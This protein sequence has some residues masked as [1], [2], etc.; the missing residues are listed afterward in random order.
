MHYHFERSSE[1]NEN[2]DAS[3]ADDDDDGITPSELEERKAQV[4]KSASDAAAAAAAASTAQQRASQ[5]MKQAEMLEARLQAQ[6]RVIQ[7][8]ERERESRDEDEHLHAIL[9]AAQAKS[10]EPVIGG[11][12]L[13]ILIPTLIGVCLLCTCVC[14]GYAILR[15][16]LL[17]V[18]STSHQGG[19][20]P[21]PPEYPWPVRFPAF[22]GGASFIHRPQALPTAEPAEFGPVAHTVAMGGAGRPAEWNGHAHFAAGSRMHGDGRVAL[23]G[24]SAV[25]SAADSA[26]FH[27]TCL[28]ASQYQQPT[29]EGLHVGEALHYQHTQPAPLLSSNSAW[30]LGGT[31]NV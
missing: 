10:D 14:A 5:R 25:V 18:T 8:E 21:G 6:E 30:D 13:A 19:P 17:K 16:T 3:T 11:L 24:R 2:N 20:P 22:A 28:A 23:G 12:P 15:V 4:R 7:E 1:R 27:S 9:A 31:L 26:L 29:H